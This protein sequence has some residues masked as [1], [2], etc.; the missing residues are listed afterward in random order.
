VFR[1]ADGSDDLAGFVANRRWDRAKLGGELA[2]VDRK[3]SGPDLLKL[4]AQLTPAGDRVYTVLCEVR[5]R[6]KGALFYYP[7]PTALRCQVSGRT[8]S[9]PVSAY[10]LLPRP[11]GLGSSPGSPFASA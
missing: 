2:V 1:G 6:E 5:F 11:S 10:S 9:F 4:L 8:G 3:P 7:S